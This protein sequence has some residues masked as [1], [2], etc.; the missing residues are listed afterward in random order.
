MPTYTTLDGDTLDLSALTAPE[1]EYL[2]VLKVAFEAGME[3]ASFNRLVHGDR[4]P[5]LEPGHRVTSA[6]ASHPIFRAAQDMEDRLG[7]RQGEIG[8]EPGDEEQLA[9]DPF[10]DE[11]LT[12][13][14]AAVAKAVTVQGVYKAIERGELIATQGRPVRVSLRSLGHWQVMDVRQAAGKVKTHAETSVELSPEAALSLRLQLQRNITRARRKQS[15]PE[16]DSLVG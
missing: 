7:I 6:V 2:G 4:N 5:I 13:A 3:W 12:I 15:A 11:W 9:R 10:S 1:A 8:A 16:S 14:E